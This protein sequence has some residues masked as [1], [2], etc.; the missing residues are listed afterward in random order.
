MPDRMP[1]AGAALLACALLLAGVTAVEG[2]AIAAG[3]AWLAQVPAALGIAL[4]HGGRRP[5]V[6]LEDAG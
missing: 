4:L 1:A 2:S 5:R 6:L 3:A